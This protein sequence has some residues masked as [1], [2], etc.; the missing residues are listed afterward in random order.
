ML[1]VMGSDVKSGHE[2][3][4]S[5]AH[6][7]LL[8]TP[9]TSQMNLSTQHD[10]SLVPSPWRSEQLPKSLLVLTALILIDLTTIVGNLLVVLAVMT[11]KSL[12]TVTNSFIVSLACADMLVAVLVMPLSIYTVIYNTW[13]FGNIVCD[14][15]ISCDVM[16]CTASILNLCCISLVGIL[17]I[18]HFLFVYIYL[19]RL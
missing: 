18:T 9:I 5:E 15:W 8:V 7:G 4:F 10:T 11:T 13:I 2:L 6:E 3:A 16:L 12:H 1:D 19:I 17:K 14:L